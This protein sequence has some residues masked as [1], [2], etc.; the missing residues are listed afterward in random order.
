[1][2]I[3]RVET[4]NFF[5]FKSKFAAD[6]SLGVNVIIGGNGTGK[7]TLIRE[8]YNI[9]KRG[10]HS[11]TPGTMSGSMVA[12][13]EA[14]GEERLTFPLGSPME[15]TLDTANVPYSI[16]IPEKDI[17]EHA[18]GLLPFIK[19]KY[20]SFT[21]VYED[22]LIAAQD[23][24]TK[25]QSETQKS[26]GKKISDIIGGY[27]EWVPSEGMYYTVKTDGSRIPF[28]H[29]ASGFKKLGLLGLLIACGRLQPGSIL[30]WDEPEN[31]LNP[32]LVPI[33]VDILLELARSGVQIFIASHNE[34]LAS[35]FD[36]NRKDEDKVM[37]VSLYKEKDIIKAKTSD[38]FDLLTPNKLTEEPVKL[39]EKK[40][41]R[42]LGDE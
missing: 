3:T 19:D 6:F 16:Y 28:T 23:V 15:L 35:Y 25:A 40:L 42:G 22:I 34:I 27:V 18:K 24:Y 1:M 38:R 13:N 9:L 41:D 26:T 39:Y 11:G 32:E 7:T 14:T 21:Q 20:T 8:M 33:L 30:F 2:A 29:E 17:L 12:K 37:F 31:S 36:V 10:F 4:G 5:V